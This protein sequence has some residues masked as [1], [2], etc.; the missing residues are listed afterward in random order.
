MN[1]LL[2]GLLPLAAIVHQVEAQT[3]QISGRVTDRT[4]GEGIPGTTVLVKGTTTGVSTNSDGSFTVS[5]PSSDAVLQISSVGYIATERTVG[6]DTQVNI[7]LAADTKQLTEIVVTGFGGAQERREITGSIATVKASDFENQPIVG[8]DQALQGRAAGVQV[9]QNSGTP[10]SG[11]AVRVRGAASLSASNEPLYVVD[12]L[13][14]NSGSYTNIGTGNQQTNALSDINPNDI[15]SIEVLKDA[16]SAAIYGSRA[17]NGVVLITT[18]RGKAGKTR[19]T[20]DY[21][22]GTQTAWK[23]PNNISGQQQTE[24]FLEMIE[25]RY[26]RAANGSIPAF[27]VPFRSYADAAAYAFGSG[28]LAVNGG[29]YQFNDDGDGVRDVAT[30]QNPSSATNTNWSDEVFRTAPITNY[31]LSFSGGNDKTRFRVGAGYFDQDGILLGSGFKRASA[32]INLENSI[33]DRVRMGLNVGLNRSVNNRIN[34]DNNI[35]GVLSAA[36][37]V[38]SDVPVRRADGT[39]YKDPGAS[40]ENPVAAAL[41]PTIKGVSGRIIGS[42]YTEFDILKNLKYRATFGLDYLT[43]KDDTFFPTTTNTGAGTSGSGTS[44]YRQDVNWNHVSALTYSNTFADAH[45]VTA[46]LI[47][48]YQRDLFNEVFAQAS[49]FPGNSVE[50]LSAGALKT[51]ASSS[52]NEWRIGGLL[53]R[54]NY[55]FRDKYLFSASIRRDVSSRFGANNRVGYFPAVSVGW[56]LVEESFIKNIAAI[57]ELKLR[58][59][60]GQTGNQEIGNFASRGLISTG[61]NFQ[62]VGGLALGQLENPDLKWERTAQTN[63]GIDF[64]LLNNRIL[65]VADAYKRDTRDLLQARLVPGST[66]FLSY[67]ANVGSIE[68][69]GLELGITTVNIQGDGTG[70]F[71]W[72]SNLNLTF[73]RNKVT[74]ILDGTPFAA[75]FASWVEQGKAL[76]SFRGYRV[77]G[78]FQ[79]QEEIDNLDRAA[80]AATGVATARYQTALTR[81]GDI[82]FRDLNG[83]GVI[84]GDD[85]EIIGNAQPKLFGGFTNTVRYKGFDLTAFIQVNLGNDIYNNTTSFTQGM[86][87]VYGQDVSVLNR[88]TPNN[89]NTDIPR[90]VYGDPNNNRRVSDRFIEDGSYGRLKNLV[91]GYTLSPSLAN[92]AKLSSVRVYVQAQNLFTITNYSGLDPEVNTFSGSNTALGTDF[93]TYPQA[94]TITGGISLGF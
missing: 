6:N 25:N 12:G 21:Y 73:N 44:S 37:L 30:F 13:P 8:V 15:E 72:T 80:V 51:G 1:K 68:N 67:Q 43:F 77:D 27:G 74:K 11:I 29:I 53:T 79:T 57:S 78:I 56:R 26:P 47:G 36:A 55:S 50:Q 9:T 86:N 18:K 71:E 89:T 65:I 92:R 64:G 10:G 66:G 23:K 3:R 19:I 84:T 83:D 16:A 70:S 31:E 93:L 48:E 39:Y 40:T 32:R 69:K 63:V 4:T 75:G 94:R 41:E 87:T 62:Q 81:P 49:G 61:A 14:I 2:L 60:Y 35:N 38:A 46:Q 28:A 85:Q 34:N 54:L 45:S 88:W 20:L 82:K 52:E 91:L 22:R 24:L 17:S 59:S 33:S 58:A 5:V 42:Q 76:G 7:G 90:A